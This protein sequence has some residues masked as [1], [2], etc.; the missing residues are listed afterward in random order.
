MNK[1]HDKDFD[2]IVLRI[3]G[4]FIDMNELNPQIDALHKALQD[5]KLLKINNYEKE[6]D[7]K[8]F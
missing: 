8:S 5:C 6:R 4:W 7:N 3:P 2:G 1:F